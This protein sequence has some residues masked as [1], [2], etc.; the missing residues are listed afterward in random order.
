MNEAGPVLEVQQVSKRF[1]GVTALHNLSLQIFPG[2]VTA[3]IGENGA[4]KSTLMKIASGVYRDYEGKVLVSNREI[5]F[6]GPKA[7]ADQGVV[8]IHQELALIPDMTITENIFL[9]RE[10]VNRSGMLDYRRMTKMAAELLAMLHLDIDP[11]TPVNRLK[12][13]Q[14]QLVEI[15]RALL[16]ESKVLIMD[17]PTSAIS[18]Q[19]VE[20]LFRII[21]NLTAKGVAVV[22]ISHKMQEIF[23]IANRYAV[24]RDGELIGTGCIRDITREELVRMMVG[25]KLADSIGKARQEPGRELLRVEN[26]CLPD[27]DDPK[28]SKVEGVSFTLHE[29]EVLGICGLMGSGRTEILESLFGLYPGRV[30]G[31]IWIRG[32]E[33][34]INS[35]AD[36]MKAGMALVPEDRKIQGLILN[37]NVARNTS[38]A[39]L[40]RISK[41]GIIQKK[42]E[43]DLSLEF[44]RKMNIQVP[45]AG[46]EVDKLSGGNQQKVVLSKWLATDPDILLLDE[47]TRGIDVGAKAE[48]YALISKLKQQG[49]GIL[50][51][52]S[53]LPEIL[54]VSD[55]ILV[56][57]ESRQTALLPRIG[58]TEE[59]IIKAALLQKTT[60]L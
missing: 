57:A 10:R 42:K 36:A 49:L 30:T 44:I 31:Q 23:E 48:I 58:T 24:L 5:R 9:G 2:E 26:L 37:M 19:E 41:F 38:L 35:I 33:K 11:S 53:E 14:Q 55:R 16:V 34:Q 25:R 6:E 50:M 40:G 17:E 29:G 56:M 8:I 1:S 15:A 4:G 60:D 28:K 27:R 59:M 18:D 12:V 51:V 47:P 3:V 39:S 52:S 21:R 45:D 32:C 13:G 46:M 22:Y 43:E 54:A 7:A 20:L